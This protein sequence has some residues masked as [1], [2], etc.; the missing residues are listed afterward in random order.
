MANQEA[1][2]KALEEYGVPSLIGSQNCIAKPTI[3][4][5]IFEITHAYI[6]IV[7]QY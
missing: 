6:Q 2:A 4:A 5:N 1:Q 3:E 7:S